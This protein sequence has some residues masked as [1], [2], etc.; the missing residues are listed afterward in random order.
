MP[1]LLSVSLLGPPRVSPHGD[2]G[3]GLPSNVFRYVFATSAVHQALLSLLTIVVFCAMS[4]RSNLQRR[5]VNDLVDGR[6]FR[7]VGLIS[8]GYAGVI[9][10]IFRLKFTMNFLMNLGTHLQVIA[11]LLV[12]GWRV[13]AGRLEIGGVVVFISGIGRLTGPWGDLVNYFRDLTSTRVKYPPF[14]DAIDGFAGR[15]L[16]NRAALG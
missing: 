13:Y 4:C 12:G 2:E 9:M 5:A 14:V 7:R 15:K 6:T 8:L 3:T 16:P 11:A 10:G 1:S